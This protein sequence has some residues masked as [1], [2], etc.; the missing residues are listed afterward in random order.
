MSPEQAAGGE[1]GRPV[2]PLL[3]GDAAVPVLTTGKKPFDGA[4]DL[5]VILQV[6]KA[7]YER[8]STFMR[9][10]NPEVRS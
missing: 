6:R 3:G 1:L 8:P 4:T 5:D 9:D 10:F 2:R 7:S